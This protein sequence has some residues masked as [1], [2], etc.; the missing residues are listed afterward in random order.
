[1]SNS[2]KE[3][4]WLPKDLAKRVKDITDAD[5][6]NRVMDEFIETSKK[7]LRI[8]IECIDEDVL[9]YRAHMVK[10]R[11][12]FK[13]A[14]E[15]E[16]ESMYSLWE[17]FD[18][19]LSAIRAKIRESIE[20][21]KPLRD[22]IKLLEKDMNSVSSTNYRLEDT[23]KLLRGFDGASDTVKELFKKAIN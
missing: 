6:I 18:K 8:N 19:D 4:V 7:E 22:E 21:I 16:L 20:V 17:S 1:M 5:A 11:D 12:K 10:A 14:K 3:L 2:E 13:E 9:L 23:L 15:A